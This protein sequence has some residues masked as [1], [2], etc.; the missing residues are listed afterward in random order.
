MKMMRWFVA[1]ALVCG[2]SR[3]AN[4]D[5]FQMVVIDPSPQY[6]TPIYN[7]S[8]TFSFSACISPQQVPTG[9][10][11]VGCFTG[12]N[13]TGKTL[14]T[15]Q[16]IIPVFSYLGQPQSAGCALFGGGLDVF[17]TVT[18]GTTPDGKD[19]F[20]DFSGG[21]IPDGNAVDCDKDGDSGDP[22]EYLEG[23]SAESIFT[24]AETGVAVD[25]FPTNMSAVAN[26][27][28]PE[29][30]SFWLLSTG[31]LSGG[32][33]LADWRRRSVGPAQG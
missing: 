32:L 8:F 30:G 10:G 28:A 22:Q 5:D 13:L 19:F 17:S 15:L 29:P 16:L 18:C 24:I 21:S 2:L 25:A 6:V 9:S 14:T 31:V 4:A 11:Y 20:L 23:C 27:S 3:T 26:A 1:I 33:F 7:S 12:V